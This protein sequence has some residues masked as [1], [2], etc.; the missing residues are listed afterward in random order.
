MEQAR[1]I[2]L[3]CLMKEVGVDEITNMQ[4]FLITRKDDLAEVKNLK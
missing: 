1:D 3:N 4:E 2:L